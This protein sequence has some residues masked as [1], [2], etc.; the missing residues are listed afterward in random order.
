MSY[1]RQFRQVLG[2]A[3]EGP[4]TSINNICKI[5]F[6]CKNTRHKTGIIQTSEDKIYGDIIGAL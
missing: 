4:K 2:R 3:E 5:I 6:L 1:P